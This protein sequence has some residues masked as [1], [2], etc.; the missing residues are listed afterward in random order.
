MLDL[1][2]RSLVARRLLLARLLSVWGDTFYAMAAM[3]VT[4]EITGSAW[5]MALVAVAEVAPFLLFSAVAGAL[6]DRWNPRRV[7]VL[8]DLTQAAVVAAVPVL[9]I[10]GLFT[11]WLLPV[12][13]F[14]LATCRTLYGPAISAYYSGAVPKED[15]AALLGLQT[16]AFRSGS[17][18]V[19]ILLGLF[20]SH[21]DIVPAFLIDALSF[22]LSAALVR[23]LPAPATAPNRATDRQPL[24]RDLRQGWRVLADRRLLLLAMVVC[25]LGSLV[26]APLYRFSLPLL[27][28]GALNAG[29]AG[30]KVLQLAQGIG[31]VVGA[32]LANQA[33]H[34]GRTYL[35]T[36]LTGWS[37]SGIGTL[38]VGASPLLLGHQG[39]LPA[40]AGL[41]LSALGTPIAYTATNVFLQTAVPRAHVGKVQ[42]LYAT[43]DMAGDYG[44]VLLMPL[45][46]TW[47][48]TES[49]FLVGGLLTVLLCAGAFLFTARRPDLQEQAAAGD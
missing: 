33:V 14:L 43:L 11:P 39:L 19:P 31:G 9:Y 27:A 20:F 44:G 29:E 26:R 37:V 7:L 21:I 34:R 15:L 1:L 28:T 2:K 3:W 32:L 41:I 22:L 12:V 5:R 4:L 24:G 17:I 16:A 25:S 35:G 42:G 38:L 6:V 8:L 47:V 18:V 48:S 45:F 49:I 40:G 46:M 13:G 10:A 36:T 30:F 23:S